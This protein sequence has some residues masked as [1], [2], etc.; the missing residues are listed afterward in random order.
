MKANEFVKKFGL[1]VAQ[2]VLKNMPRT[3]THYVFNKTGF[4]HALEHMSYFREGEWFDSDYATAEELEEDYQGNVVCLV[5]LRKLSVAHEVVE[6]KGGLNTAKF[7][8]QGA[9]KLT[10]QLEQKGF[11]MNGVPNKAID[12]LRQAIAGVESCQ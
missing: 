5:Q 12:E 3:S 11:G 6:A 1:E 10:Y 8:V 2:C 7:L 9:D 4:Y